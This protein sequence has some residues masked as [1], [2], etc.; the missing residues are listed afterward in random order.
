MDA[1]EMNTIE[2]LI[3]KKYL[4]K[5][6]KEAKEIKYTNIGTD[7]YQRVLA[8]IYIDGRK[9]SEIMIHSGKARRWN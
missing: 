6:L 8:D 7:K 5:I 9:V 1:P 3:S 4:I 2:G